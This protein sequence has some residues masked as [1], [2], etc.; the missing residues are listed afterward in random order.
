MSKPLQLRNELVLFNYSHIQIT[1][2]YKL[3]SYLAQWQFSKYFI[4]LFSEWIILQYTTKIKSDA[5]QKKTVKECKNVECKNVKT[6]K[7]NLPF[8]V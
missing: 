8:P 1:T 4:A 5:F 2:D 3:T 7:L 6:A